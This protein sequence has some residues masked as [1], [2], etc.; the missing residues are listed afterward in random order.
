MGLGASQRSMACPVRRSSGRT[1]PAGPFTTARREI[2]RKGRSHSGHRAL[3]GPVAEIEETR[4]ADKKGNDV[5]TIK[6]KQHSSHQALKDLAK[7]FRMEVERQEI[8]G[9]NGGPFEV[10]DHRRSNDN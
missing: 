9:P 2:G 7:I 6:I 4:V 5:V 3:S 8:R 1:I 10:T